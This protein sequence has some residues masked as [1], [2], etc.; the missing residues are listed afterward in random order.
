M[1]FAVAMEGWAFVEV[2]ITVVALYI[3]K[4]RLLYIEVLMGRVR[5]K[6]AE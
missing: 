1:A 4:Y 6:L 2:D 5:S 3:K